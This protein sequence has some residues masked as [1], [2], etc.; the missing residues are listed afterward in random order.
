MSD[1]VC[2]LSRN[3]AEQCYYNFGIGTFEHEILL[4]K[5]SQPQEHS[6]NKK[7]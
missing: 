2:N 3:R 7:I 6:Y 4:V 5:M 1:C